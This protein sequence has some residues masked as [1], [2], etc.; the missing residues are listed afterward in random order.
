VAWQRWRN[1]LPYEV[2]ETMPNE[3]AT[4][5][6]HLTAR[7]GKESGDVMK[8]IHEAMVNREKERVSMTLG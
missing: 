6:L 1:D 8:D 4:V 2:L 7:F 5:F 3:M